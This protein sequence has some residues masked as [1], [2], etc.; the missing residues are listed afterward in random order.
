MR[1]RHPRSIRPLLVLAGALVVAV[2]L[3]AVAGDTL[4][5]RLPTRPQTAKLTNQPPLTFTTGVLQRDRH[6]TWQLRDGTQLSVPRD[7]VWREEVGG[8]ETDPRSGR[9]VLIAGQRYGASL[10]VRQATLLDR[11]RQIGENQI[12]PVAPPDQPEPDL[13]K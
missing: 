5:L 6:G 2:A 13:P 4:G 1:E 8:K 11:S 7:V 9:L 10:V 12:R 3:S